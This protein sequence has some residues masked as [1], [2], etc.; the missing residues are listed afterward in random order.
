[1]SYNILKK[2]MSEKY[3][4]T[5]VGCGYVGMSLSVLLSKQHY[6]NV[7]DIDETK[8]LQIN[9][10][11]STINDPILQEFISDNDLNLLATTN[12]KEAYKNADY[13][14]I[15]TPTD[16]N[17][18]SHTFDTTSVDFVINDVIANNKDCLIVIKST[19]PVGYTESL[20]TKYNTDRIIFSP[21]F[22]RENM[23]LQD[24]LYPSRIIIGN[25]CMKSKLFAKIL[26]NAA[27]K[28]NI[29]TIFVSSIEAESIK[30]FSNTFLAMRVSF[31]NE[32]DSFAYAKK[33]SAKNIINGVFLDERIGNHYNNPSFGYGGYCLPKDTKQLL[34]NYDMVPQTLMQ[35]IVNSN[36]TRKDF[37]AN[38]I[39]KLNP[40]LVGFYRLAMK[41]GS[42]NFRSSAIQGVIKRICA[43]GIEVVI[44]EP[45]IENK[46]KGLRIISDIEEFKEVSDVIVSNRN[47]PSLENVSNKVFT[48]DI[49]GDN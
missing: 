43:E 7:F 23:A 3:N 36:S 31:F 15:A 32:L 38:E 19:I 33:M 44:Y 30:L 6:V 12:K 22:L 42:D 1:M 25:N 9:S 20:N 18:E 41:K 13:V 21:E 29:E 14:I 47:Y 26:A 35:A 24:C 16:Y 39:I 11:K 27:R 34:A 45:E 10:G 5:V 4:I 48:R 17:P 28:D 8:I 49:F 2:N 37:I 40:K 46:F